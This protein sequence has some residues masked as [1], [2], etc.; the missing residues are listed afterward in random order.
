MLLRPSK[1]TLRGSIVGGREDLAEAI[2]FAAN[3]KIRAEIHKVTLEDINQFS[4]ISGL[5][6]EWPNRDHDVKRRLGWFGSFCRNFERFTG[7]PAQVNASYTAAMCRRR[8]PRQ[9]AADSKWRASRPISHCQQKA[10]E[11]LHGKPR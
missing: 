7:S 1:P 8:A 11:R 6:C 3:G 2:A 4:M 5:D 10:I 9:R